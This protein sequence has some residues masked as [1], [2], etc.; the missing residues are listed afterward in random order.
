[1]TRPIEVEAV[2]NELAG[3]PA[4]RALD[5]VTPAERRELKKIQKVELRD[6]C[7]QFTRQC[8]LKLMDL[9]ERGRT[10]DI[11]VRAAELVLSYGWGKPTQAVAGQ[12]DGR[13]TISWLQ[14][15]DAAKVIDGSASAG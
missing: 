14:P 3:F 13:L 8:V 9:V 7:Q 10:E 12:F 4:L 1:M 15:G 2:R 5:D 6:L 11:Q